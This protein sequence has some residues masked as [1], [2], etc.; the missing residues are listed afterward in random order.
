MPRQYSLD[1][2]WRIIYAHLSMQDLTS[3]EIAK[4]FNVC[5]RTVRRYIRRFQLSSEMES[6][7]HQHGRSLL[8]GNF[9]QLTLLRIIFE[10][11]G[12]YL[13]EIQGK[14]QQIYGVWISPST[15]CRTLKIM[16]CSRQAMHRVATQRSDE[17]RAR[18]MADVSIYDPSMLVW[19][20][21]SGCDK[22]NTIR[23]Y[24]YSIRGIPMCD[25]RLL[26]RGTRY[27]AIP[28]VSTTGIHDIYLAERN[29]DGSKFV[30]F[31]E[32]SLLPVLNPFNGI[33]TH[34]VVIMDNATIHH[35]DEVSDLVEGHAG[36]K[37]CYLPPYSPDLNPVE[38]IFSQVKSIMKEEREF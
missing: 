34:S 14:L 5:E 8:L 17:L 28:I 20:D 38:G 26:N 23:K 1:L 25:Q 18:F 2:R 11:P 12:I 3:G 35:I 33:N 19:L 29:V 7:Q 13:K 15:I 9:E 4:L 16:G 6:K 32:E 36:A 37:L 10:N 21:E 22:R 31:V 24:G 30:K 27:S